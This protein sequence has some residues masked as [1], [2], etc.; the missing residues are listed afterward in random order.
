MTQYSIDNSSS[1]AFWIKQNGQ[2]RYA[3]KAACLLTGYSHQE[4]MR[5]YIW[6]L[7]L[8]YTRDVFH[9]H[10]QEL[11][12]KRTL[13]FE[14]IYLGRGGR[15]VPIEVNTNLQE[16]EKEKYIFAYVSDITE[17]EKSKMEQTR[18][19]SAIEQSSD[20]VIITDLDGNIEYVNPAFERSTGYS[21]AEVFGENPRIIKS[22]KHGDGFY[23][24][25]WETISGGEIW[26]GNLINKRKDGKLIEESATIFP[27]LNSAGGIENFVAVKRDM[28]EQNKIEKHLRQSQKLEAIGTLSSGIAHDFNNILAAIFGYTQLSKKRLPDASELQNVDGYLDKIL[29]AGS[30]AKDLIN[31]ILTLSRKGS[32]NPINMDLQPVLKESIKFLRATLPSTISIKLNIDPDLKKIYGDATQIQQVIMNLCTNASHAMEDKGG[33]L[34]VSLSNCRIK[35]KTID[36]GNLD[37]GDYVLLTV[38]DI[39]KGM[40]DETKQRIFEPFFTTKDKGKGTGLGLSVVH[41]IV[42]KHGGAIKVFSQLG[43]GTKFKVYFPISTDDS[44]Q[45]E[46]AS[47]PELAT[48]SEAIL[49]VDDEIDLCDIYGEMLNMQGYMVQ[50]TNCSRDAL[51]RFK[52]NPDRFQLVITDYTMPEIGGLELSREI[53]RLKPNVP[54]I[55]LSG[56]EQLL[57]NDDLKTTGIV[58]KYSKPVEMGTLI[59][60]VRDALDNK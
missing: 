40:S 6:D 28:T 44:V 23:R 27:V 51:N 9:T 21:R 36:T 7:V 4:L 18:L 10:W 16:F 8:R 49:F 11:E 53:Q 57:S 12:E 48:G 14:S 46:I 58:A 31:Q 1:A 55:L 47:E 17:R 60:G 30:R 35:L 38:S 20:N 45:A 32:H 34:V 54:I 42:S 22:G 25:L 15:Q 52:E 43:F 26:S 13:T 39:G 19:V 33:P 5:M 2:I 37:P 24:N 3:N 56:V 41:G 50:T 29:S 59:K